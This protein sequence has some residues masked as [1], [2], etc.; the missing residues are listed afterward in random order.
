MRQSQCL[1]HLLWMQTDRRRWLAR[2]TWAVV[3][4]S[5]IALLG[6]CSSFRKDT[7]D[8]TAD[9]EAEKTASNSPPVLM[10]TVKAP[11]TLDTLLSKNLDLA[12]VNR[13]ARG[14][15]LQEGEFERLLNAAPAQARALLQ[16]AGYFTPQIRVDREAGDPPRVLITVDPGP[17][18]TVASVDIE[19]A[20]PLQVAAESG[21]ARA[22]RVRAE[23]RSEW[24]LNEGQPFVSS[25]WSKAKTGVTAR[26]RAD[27]YVLADWERTQARVDAAAQSAVLSGTVTSGPLFRTGPLQIEGLVRQDLETVENIAAFDAG[28][29]ATEM[30]LLDFQERLQKSG[31]FTSAVVTL[32]PED[33]DPLATPVLVRL[34]EQ[35]IHEA[36]VGI[37]FS[38]NLGAR[39]TLDYTN[40]RPFGHALVARNRLEIAQI[41]QRWDGELSTQTLPGLYRNLIGGSFSR[42][43]SN[44]DVV[45]AGRL[46]AGRAQETK[47]IS[48]LGFIEA[49]RSVKTSALGRETSDALSGHYHG[50]WRKVDD[51]LLPTDGRV[52]TGQLGGGYASSNPGGN[53]PFARAYAKFDTFTP[54]AGNWHFQ[55]RIELGEVFV[56]DNVIVP[57]SMR[58]RAGGDES[59]RGYGYRRLTP[60]IDGVDT[61]GKVL[62]T[63]SAEVAR[64]ILASI[65]ELWGAAFIDI[66]RAANSWSRIDPAV[67]VGV[68]VRFRSPVGPLKLDL[69]YGEE[70]QEF[71]VHLTVGVS[72]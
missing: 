66:G 41:Q 64:P 52:W 48:R 43:E 15:P 9:P 16:T 7:P 33:A 46:R 56:R 58:F 34:T 72:F 68:G 4:V 3:V 70:T 61:G 14:E 51:L 71:R 49:E 6:G 32:K 24:S 53:G 17:M 57:E 67:G 28:V 11:G 54:F 62:F 8:P 25:A 69:A 30:L 35:K 39:T 19:V 44:T 23:V 10:L 26:L 18:T 27:A 47:N 65:P 1:F 60:Q 2:R 55:G 40:T 31:L 13:L 42:V 12:Q 21:D 29:P 38:A 36:T 45:T 50:I 63:A 22:A 5:S 59:V 20:G 37:G